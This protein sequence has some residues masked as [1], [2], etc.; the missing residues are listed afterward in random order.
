[1]TTGGSTSGRCT[2][3]S[4][5]VRPGKRPR[6]RSMATATPNGRLTRVATIETRRLSRMA[7]S[8]AGVKSPMRGMRQEPG[9]MKRNPCASKKGFALAEI[10]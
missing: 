7:T 10:R 6:A 1:M 5:S 4:S 9:A 3:P 8:S 2:I